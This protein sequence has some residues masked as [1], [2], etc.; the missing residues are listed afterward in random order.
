MKKFMLV[1]VIA[2]NVAG[3]VF[4]QSAGNPWGQVVTIDGTLGLQNGAIVLI[5]GNTVYFVPDLTRYVG[6]V[7]GL[8]EGARVNVQG[9]VGGYNTLM[10][11]AFTVNGKFYDVSTFAMGGGYCGGY[12]VSMGHHGGGWGRGRHW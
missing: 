11:T 6:F 2:A 3:A 4:A 8:K 9:Y 7:D 5:S 1:L 12:G 10:P